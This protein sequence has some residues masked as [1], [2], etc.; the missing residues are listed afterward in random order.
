MGV[1]GYEKETNIQFSSDMF[2]RIFIYFGL[3]VSS[4]MISVIKSG[5]RRMYSALL[6]DVSVAYLG[7][8]LTNEVKNKTISLCRYI[9]SPFHKKRTRYKGIIKV[10]S[11]VKMY[12]VV[13]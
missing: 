13:V 12:A 6:V 3:L 8:Y 2:L 10:S 9:I 5:D 4:I 7:K 11:P 1:F